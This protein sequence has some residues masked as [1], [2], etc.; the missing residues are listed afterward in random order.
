MNIAF[1]YIVYSIQCIFTFG[2]VN[3]LVYLIKPTLY[4]VEW[5]IFLLLN[6]AGDLH[7]LKRI[8][9]YIRCCIQLGTRSSYFDG[10]TFRASP[11]GRGSGFGQRRFRVDKGA[12]TGAAGPDVQVESP[13]SGPLWNRESSDICWRPYSAHRSST[14]SRTLLSNMYS[15]TGNATMIIHH[16]L[17]KYVNRKFIRRGWIFNWVLF[18]VGFY[19]SFTI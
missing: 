8:I 4:D 3:M 16:S 9:D 14:V 13:R 17:S 6:C 18:T 10:I 7:R 5:W 15:Y 11:H 1:A 19:F 12:G 2:N